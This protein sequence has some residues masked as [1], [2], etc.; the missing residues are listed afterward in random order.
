M[1]PVAES[2]TEAGA[3]TLIPGVWTTPTVTVLV[4]VG[5]GIAWMVMV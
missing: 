3:V 1:A 5:A 4:P 2:I